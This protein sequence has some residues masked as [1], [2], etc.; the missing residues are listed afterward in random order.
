MKSLNKADCLAVFH[1]DDG[2]ISRHI[3]TLLPVTSTDF[4]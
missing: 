2:I 3:V 1:G 4:L